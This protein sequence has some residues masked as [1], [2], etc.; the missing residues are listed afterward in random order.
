MGA[1]G[2]G[3]VKSDG[4]VNRSRRGH[5]S[6]TNPQPLS[7]IPCL[8]LLPRLEV[9]GVENLVGAVVRQNL[10]DV[11]LRLVEAAP[12]GEDSGGFMYR[13]RDPARDVILASVLG[14]RDRF[15][16]ARKHLSQL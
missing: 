11:V 16:Q 9:V 15:G 14:G 12:G 3:I 8:F 6:I 4:R 10:V 5:R 13:A 7:P 1:R 2:R